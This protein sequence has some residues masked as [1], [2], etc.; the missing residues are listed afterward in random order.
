MEG[1]AGVMADILPERGGREHGA[2]EGACGGAS[3]TT[4]GAAR[5]DAVSEQSDHIDAHSINM[6]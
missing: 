4:E 3:G 2:C 5:G 1:R 6:Y